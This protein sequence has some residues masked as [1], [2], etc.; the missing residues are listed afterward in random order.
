MKLLTIKELEELS[1]IQDENCISI[2]LPTHRSGQETINLQDARLLKTLLQDLKHQL[3]QR[4]FNEDEAMH[5]L[6]PAAD[7]IDDTGFWRR[8]L[9]GL[10]IFISKGFFRYYRLPLS[11]QQFSLLTDSFYLKSLA[12]AVNN[13]DY[14]Y[15]LAISLHK[16]RFFEAGRFFI[17]ELD[18][19]N[20][21]PENIGEILSY[22][23]FEGGINRMQKTGSPPSPNTSYHG[24]G[25]V[26]K[27]DVPYIKEYFRHIN[28]GLNRVITSKPYP[29]VLAA[30]GFLHP[31]YKEVNTVANIVE[32]GIHGN[33]ER[34]KAEEIHEESKKIMEPYF[35]EQ[36]ERRKK[37]YQR[38]AGTGKTSYNIE[39][40]A[41]AALNGRVEA[42]FTTPGS[43]VWGKI[44]GE[45][46]DPQFEIHDHFE[47]NDK[48]LIDRSVVKTLLNGGETYIVDKENLPET[49]V[50]TEIAAVFRY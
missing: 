29:M 45:N 31:I 12:P 39:E 26:K 42:L 9:E 32:E 23:D 22:Y 27:D 38:L 21:F 30:V 33:P 5:Y 47:R 7:L 34:M 17:N 13:H 8:Q 46:R 11:F 19:R 41:R 48:C 37:K 25:S 50:K 49:G 18:L 20:L 4:G 1:A 36:S 35:R 40:I 6:K 14:Y 15:I 2:F 43:H 16:I 44:Y 28:E 3:Q 24:Q 10:A